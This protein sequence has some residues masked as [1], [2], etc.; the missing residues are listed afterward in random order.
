MFS[1]ANTLGP[2]FLLT[3]GGPTYRLEQRLGLI[4]EKSP[5]IARSSFFSLLL[6][7]VPLFALSALE[8]L[9]VG[10]RVPVPFLQ[11][12]A[13]HARFLLAV[14]LLLIAENVLGPRLA[15]AAEH[16]VTSRLVT[17]EEYQGFDAA[18]EKGLRWRDSTLAEILLLVLAYIATCTSLSSMAVHVSTWY[19]LRTESG[20]SLTMGRMV[21]Y[22]DLRSSV[23]VFGL[24]LDVQ[25]IFMGTV[26]L[27]YEPL[28][29]SAHPDTSR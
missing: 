12:F 10:H 13:V 1:A 14:P 26:S 18:I 22:I 20:I 3:E 17:E 23:S 15:H 6:T 11:D 27:A 4:R 2:Q 5:M 9:A 19:A 8:K 25:A 21:V 16:F 29:S 28:E 7:W 24:T